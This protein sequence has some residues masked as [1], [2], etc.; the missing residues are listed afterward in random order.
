MVISDYGITDTST[1]ENV[2]IEDYL[3]EDDYQ[4]VTY[5][6]GYA[7]IV[8]YALG[9]SKILEDCREMEGV[10]VFLTDQVQDP[11]I[12][13]GVKIP[14]LFQYGNGKYVQDIL[15]VA[16]PAYQ[17]ISNE[18]NEKIINVNG[19][20]DDSVLKGGAG[21]NP[22]LQEVKYPKIK[23][24]I[25]LTTEQAQAISDYKDFHKYKYDMQTRAYMMGPG[26]FYTFNNMLMENNIAK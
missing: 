5:T 8:P 12:W 4:Y 3:D 19:L 11:P 2:N 9:H 26:N 10:D 22:Y 20:L 6:T 24:G 17:L 23:R 14:E 1:I 21:R 18:S 13:H 25:P 7:Q 15:L 16:K